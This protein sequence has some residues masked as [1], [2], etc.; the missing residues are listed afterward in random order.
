MNGIALG[1]HSSYMHDTSSTLDLSGLDDFN[2]AA[3]VLML[4]CV[5]HGTQANK[6]CQLSGATTAL[7]NTLTM[8]SP[9]ELLAG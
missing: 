4:D 9:E 3:L 8:A 1:K 5:R 2:S 6:R 7:A